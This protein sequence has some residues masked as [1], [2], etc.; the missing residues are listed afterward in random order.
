MRKLAFLPVVLLL[1]MLPCSGQKSGSIGNASYYSDK[2]H[3]RR[4]SNGDKYHRDSMT[5]AHLKYKLGTKLLVQN[6][7]NGKEVVVTVTDRGP[8][9]KRFIIDLSRAAA[10]QLGIIQKGFAEVVVTLY[11]P[12]E[13]PYRMNDTIP[14]PE[15]E[16]ENHPASL[17][18]ILPDGEVM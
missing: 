10:M 3:G 13:V 9:S 16:L 5:C 6:P 2:L 14:I 8:H 18:I 4:M 12:L 7:A 15:L 17:P 11:Q 1:C